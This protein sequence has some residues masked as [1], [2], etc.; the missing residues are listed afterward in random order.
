MQLDLDD[1]GL[2]FPTK[3]G[4]VIVANRGLLVIIANDKGL[5]RDDC[6]WWLLVIVNHGL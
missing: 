6:Y 2:S 5:T 3:N 4:G 1:L